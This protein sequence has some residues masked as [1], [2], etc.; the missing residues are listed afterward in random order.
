VHAN[1]LA[2]LPD[3][4][5]SFLGA[6][7]HDDGPSRMADIASRLGVDAAYAGQYGWRMIA[8]EVIEPR[9]YGLVNFNLPEVTRSRASW[10]SPRPLL[11][12]C[13]RS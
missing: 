7:A 12:L 9:G 4:D 11:S 6:M 3:V 8:A 10:R 5:R 13:C 2:D 1:A